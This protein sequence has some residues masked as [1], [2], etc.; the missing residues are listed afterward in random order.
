MNFE[1]AVLKGKAGEAFRGLMAMFKLEYQ[2]MDLLQNLAKEIYEWPVNL[3]KELKSAEDKHNVQRVKLEEKLRESRVNFE[4]RVEVYAEDLDQY[5]NFTEYSNYK[6]YITDITEF[7]NLLI[8]AEN[9]MYEIQDHEKK[10]FGIVSQHDKFVGLKKTVEPY[11]DFWNTVGEFLDAKRSWMYGSFKQ[12]NPIDVE[13]MV[14]THI[15][16]SNKLSKMFDKNPIAGRLAS[17]F[18]EDVQSASELLPMI[19]VLCNPGLKERHWNMIEDMIQFKFNP[20]EGTL[21]EILARGVNQHFV[22]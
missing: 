3:D 21:K 11:V 16:S 1:R 20:E 8:K 12:V 4:I 17:E 9:E 6:K 22:Q 18:K 7:Q 13:N 19:E 14:K 15:K 5:T 10:L 2:K